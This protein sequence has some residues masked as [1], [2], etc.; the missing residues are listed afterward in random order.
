MTL[1]SYGPLSRYA[2]HYIQGYRPNITER[3]ELVWA[4]D[5]RSASARVRADHLFSCEGTVTGV[6][7]EC[8]QC[9]EMHGAG[10]P[11]LNTCQYCGRPSDDYEATAK[12]AATVSA[13][14]LCEECH[15][16]AVRAVEMD[17]RDAMREGYGD[18][19]RDEGKDRRAMR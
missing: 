17:R 9:G 3:T 1:L 2:V 4:V 19:L 13:E 18:W 14:R 11:W 12:D 6:E 8:G 5:E 16:S 10:C 7:R 15:A